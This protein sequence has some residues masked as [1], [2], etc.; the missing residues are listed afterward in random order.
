MSDREQFIEWC[1]LNNDSWIVRNVPNVETFKVWD[2]CSAQYEARIAKLEADVKKWQEIAVK[3]AV[4]EEQADVKITELE[5]KLAIDNE[6]KDYRT[7]LLLCLLS[8]IITVTVLYQV[9]A[10]L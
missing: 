1:Q 4:Y 3:H 6:M 2:A 5:A 7:L 8:A 10:I 9:F